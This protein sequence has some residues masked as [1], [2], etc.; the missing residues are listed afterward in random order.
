MQCCSCQKATPTLLLQ[1]YFMI[2]S[3]PLPGCHF[4]TMLQM[5]SKWLFSVKIG[6]RV[7]C[8]F[9]LGIALTT[10]FGLHIREEGADRKG[11]R[12]RGFAPFLGD[13]S[14]LMKLHELQ[15]KNFYSTTYLDVSDTMSSGMSYA[16][17]M[18]RT[19]AERELQNAKSNVLA[20]L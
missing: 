9:L 16:A 14:D 3:L 8:R 15:M 1:G 5:S 4:Q 6:C 12:L 10:H 19:S 18:R 7:S 13:F 17:K 20:Y 2:F 11:V